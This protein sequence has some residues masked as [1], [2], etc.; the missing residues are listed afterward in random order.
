LFRQYL[1]LVLVQQ[2]ASALFRT[3]GA[4]GRNIIVANTLGTFFLLIL[5]ALSG[6]V[7]SRGIVSSRI[8]N[9]FFFGLL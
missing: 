8:Q 2:M 6:V 3:I 5:F 9:L 7:L 1:L 4:V